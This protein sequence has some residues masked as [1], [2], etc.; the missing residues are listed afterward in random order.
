MARTWRAWTVAMALS[1]VATGVQAQTASEVR[2]TLEASM[3]V[4]GEIE[5]TPQGSVETYNVENA[6]KLPPEVHRLLE[7]AIPQWKFNPVERDGQAVAARSKMNLRLV[8]R[9]RDDGNYE[10][11]IRSAQ[12]DGE[13]QPG[14][15]VKG[16]QMSPPRYPPTAAQFG[17]GGNVYLLMRVGRDGK[18]EDVVAEQTNLLVVDSERNMKKWRSL[19]EQSAIEAARRWTFA[20]PT[21]GA[22]VGDAYW[23]VRVPVSYSMGRPSKSDADMWQVYIPG[24]RNI[25]P[26]A[27]PDVAID[28]G[29]DAGVDGSVTQVGA[30]LQLKTPLGSG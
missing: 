25:I 9:K 1:M 14:A 11:S 20:P 28:T 12:F 26:W 15:T 16:I 6:G 21:Q 2:K 24:P 18:V 4:G 29:I 3:L 23:Q 19:L 22:S 30:G 13:P 17:V 27:N 5:I 8:A 7:Q 10:M